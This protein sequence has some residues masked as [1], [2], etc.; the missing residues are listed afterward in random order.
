MKTHRGRSQNRT[1]TRG[2]IRDDAAI[3][4]DTVIEVMKKTRRLVMAKNNM[5]HWGSGPRMEHKPTAGN[6]RAPQ[7]EIISW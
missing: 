7:V 4:W 2:P 6:K 1:M 3:R 5:D